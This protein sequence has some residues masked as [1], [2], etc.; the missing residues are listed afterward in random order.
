MQ[1]WCLVC[2]ICYSNTFHSFIFKLCI[3]IVHTLSLFCA[4]LIIFSQF[5]RVLNLELFSLRN[6]LGCIVCVI[7][8]SNSFHSFIWKLC[9]MIR[10][11]MCISDFA[12]VSRIFCF[13]FGVLNLGIFTFKMLRW[14]LVCGIS[15]SYSFHIF[16]IQTLH[17][18]WSFMHW[19]CVPPILCTF[20]KYF[21]LNL[22]IFPSE[23]VG[24]SDLC[25]L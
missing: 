1:R 3:M 21:P 24:V 11:K 2:V 19:T 23:M 16:I 8:N 6:G 25:N 13:M 12:H 20:E 18:D 22:D 15:N 4:H 17:N 14:C 10:L 9:M 7:C 5:W